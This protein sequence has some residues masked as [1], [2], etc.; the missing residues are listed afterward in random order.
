[1]INED[2]S[3]KISLIQ[4][5]IVAQTR[6]KVSYCKAWKAKQKVVVNIFGDWEGSYG[7]L[8]RFLKYMQQV[9]SGFFYDLSD[10]DFFIGRR[11]H[12]EFRVFRRLFWTYKSCSDAF[13][14]CKPLIQ[15]DGTHL[16]GKY[17]GILLMATTQDDNNSILPLAFSIVEGETLDNW[18]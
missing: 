5:R 18:S 15:I 1:M 6:Y 4:E 13:Q 9:V 7:Y 12:R 17:K 8:P 14:F 11:V 10:D 16:Y 3:I 2:P